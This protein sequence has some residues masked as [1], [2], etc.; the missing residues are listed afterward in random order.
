MGPSRVEETTT[1]EGAAEEK[2]E[3]QGVTER[4]HGALTPTIDS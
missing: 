1:R 3:E 2:G 4:Y